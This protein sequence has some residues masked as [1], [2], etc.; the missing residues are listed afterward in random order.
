[1][2]ES[3][4]KENESLKLLASLLNT[5]AHPIRLMILE[6]LLTGVKCVKDLNDLIP[7]SQPS[8]SQHI[9]VLREAG[10]IESQSRGSLRCYYVIRP[11]LVE[12]LL[13]LHPDQHPV[14]L[15][16]RESIL[17]ELNESDQR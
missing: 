12:K 16:S 8:L 10:L 9:A 15:R 7:I 1:M 2:A 4:G 11:S 13:D 5:V 3:T 14:Q 17:D 6:S